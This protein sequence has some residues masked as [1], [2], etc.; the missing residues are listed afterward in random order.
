MSPMSYIKSWFPPILFPQRALPTKLTADGHLTDVLMA[1][2]AE[3]AMAEA[4]KINFPDDFMLGAATA[5][6]QVEG[7]LHACNWAAWERSGRNGEHFAGKACDHWTLFEADVKRMKA[8]GLRMYRF[9]VDWSRCEPQEGTFDEAALHRYASWCKLL[10]ANGIEPMVTLHHFVE[11]EWFD[12]LGGWEKAENVRYFRRFADAVCAKLCPHCTYWCTLNELNGFAMC[13]WVAGIHPPGKKDDVFGMIVVIKNMLVAHTQACRAIR[14]ASAGCVQV[15]GARNTP[16]AG[17]GGA[18]KPIICLANSHIL[19]TPTGGYGPMA[20]FSAITAVLV[21]YLFNYLYADMLIL[22]R[23]AWPVQ[24]LVWI[25]GWGQDLKDLK[26]TVD[27]LGLNH[28][29]RSVVRYEKVSKTSGRTPGA[30]DLFIH[31]PFGVALSAMGIAGF[32]KSEMGWC[33]PLTLSL[34]AREQPPV[35][36]RTPRTPLD[37]VVSVLACVLRA[38]RRD[39][40]PSS[41][42]A[43]IRSMHQR[44]ACPMIVTESGIADG[45]APDVQ[46]TRYLAATLGVAERMRAEGVDLR[47]WLIWTLMDNF[48]WAEGFRPRFGLLSTNFKTLARGE[49][50][51][52]AILKKIL[53]K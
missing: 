32:E 33:A 7:G 14:Q 20:L 21:S 27:C 37:P 45:G 6:Y 26:G 35:Y 50:A 51:S 39:L 52:N 15:A 44:Y 34:A 5:A 43:L 25:L 4:A 42:E 3:Q 22:G 38:S 40:T 23:V 49:R 17:A 12:A 28:Y 41:W 46:R 36:R 24:L 48:E 29:Y 16:Q 18:P 10:R 19:F 8:L 2:T 9:S 30:G 31:L 11:P 1:D 53:V 13:G 47:G